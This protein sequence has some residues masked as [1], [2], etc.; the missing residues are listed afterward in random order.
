MALTLKMTEDTE[1]IEKRQKCLD[2]LRRNKVSA[3][4]GDYPE[5]WP[6]SHVW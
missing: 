5:S 6:V 2:Y 1:H 4:S 3:V